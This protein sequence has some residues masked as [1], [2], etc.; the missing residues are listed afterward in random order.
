[1]NILVTGASGYVGKRVVTLALQAGHSVKALSRSGKL[2][3]DL[4]TELADST[5]LTAVAADIGDIPALREAC[6][7]V[8]AIIH[9]VGIIKERKNASFEQVHVEGTR[10]V[11]TAALDTGVKR[12][13]HMSALGATNQE[14][15]AQSGY[16]KTK[17]E[18]ESIVKGS[19]LD[20]TVFR[21]SLIFGQDD[22]F[23][24]TVLRQLVSLPPFIPQIGDGSFLFKPVWLGDVAAAFVQALD[25]PNS[26]GKS[27]DLVGPIEY[28]FRDLL[29]LERKSLTALKSPNS[30][31]SKKPI[32][33]IPLPLMKLAVPVMQILPN[34][35]IT[36][37]QFAMLLAGNTSSS[38]EAEETFDLSMTSLESKLKQMLA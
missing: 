18:A 17:A 37:D 23:F 4:P 22:E 31:I 28:S 19:A 29:E 1:M 6:Q 25:N 30:F 5:Q 2:P 9:L 32:I 10:N 15:C 27:Y 11:V 35:P 3:T 36:S 13:V 38:T 20:W 12:Y 34:P 16:M 24:S 14:L 33:P 26:F 8:D 7:G 21:P